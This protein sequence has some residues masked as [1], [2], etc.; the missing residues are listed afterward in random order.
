[1][2]IEFHPRALQQLVTGRRDWP[3]ALYEATVRLLVRMET[4][5]MLMALEAAELVSHAGSD[6]E[7]ARSEAG[8][9]WIHVPEANDGAVIAIVWTELRTDDVYVHRI[10]RLR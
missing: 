4:T 6:D 9:T 7:L 10:D 3:R 1:M 8:H 2:T 5:P